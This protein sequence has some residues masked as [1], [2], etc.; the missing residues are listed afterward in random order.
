MMVLFIVLL[1]CYCF[2]K[3]VIYAIIGNRLVLHEIDI[4][5]QENIK[6][7]CNYSKLLELFFFFLRVD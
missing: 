2:L 3:F 1:H 4:T 6:C 7:L 5:I